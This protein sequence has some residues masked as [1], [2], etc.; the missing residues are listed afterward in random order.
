MTH[1]RPRATLK[2][3]LTVNACK[4]IKESVLINQ[5]KLTDAAVRTKEARNALV[6]RAWAR[7]SLTQRIANG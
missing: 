1:K 6:T 4:K 5:N 2:S 3:I 7:A